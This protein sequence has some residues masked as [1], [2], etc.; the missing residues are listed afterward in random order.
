MAMK[1]LL[2]LL[3]AA[4]VSAKVRYDRHQVFRVVPEEEEQLQALRDLEEQSQGV[5]SL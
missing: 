5:S 1:W 3:L 4:I 2:W